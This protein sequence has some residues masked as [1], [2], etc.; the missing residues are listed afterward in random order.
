MTG[1][2]STGLAFVISN[3]GNVLTEYQLD[4]AGAGLTAVTDLPTIVIPAGGTAVILVGITADSAGN[5]AL[6]GSATAVGGAS[7]SATA[8]LTFLFDGENQP[9]EVNA[10]PDKLANIGQLLPFNGSAADPDGD[11][12]VSIAWDFGDGHTANGT[13][14]PTHTYIAAGIYTVTLTATDSRGGVG[15]ANLQVDVKSR[16][17]L[18]VIIRSP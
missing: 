17:Y 13:L 8:N 12:I 15:V 7:N 10:G 18:P 2:L 6:T 4:F 11:A 1:T 16:L 3:T 9:P 5:Y 14:T